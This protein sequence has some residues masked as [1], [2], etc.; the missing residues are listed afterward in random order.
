LEVFYELESVADMAKG[1]LETVAVVSKEQ[2]KDPTL[3]ETFRLK[4]LVVNDSQF[5]RCN[6]DQIGLR[7]FFGTSTRLLLQG[8]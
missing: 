6:F 4:H 3:Q 5:P 8:V 7:R 2:L 1:Q